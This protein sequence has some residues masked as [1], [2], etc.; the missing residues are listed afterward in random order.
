MTPQG[1]CVIASPTAENI[2]ERPAGRADGARLDL[3][4]ERSVGGLVEAAPAACPAAYCR[5]LIKGEQLKPD[6]GR[7]DDFTWPRSQK[8]TQRDQ[9]AGVARNAWPQPGA[10]STDR[11]GHIRRL[12]PAMDP[13]QKSEEARPSAP[14]TLTVAHANRIRAPRF[15]ESRRLG[16]HRGAGDKPK[17]LPPSGKRRFGSAEPEDNP[18]ALAAPRTWGAHDGRLPVMTCLSNTRLA[19][20]RSIFMRARP[21][22]CST[23]H[24]WG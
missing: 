6:A 23:S 17:G 21:L 8:R 16:S 9:M 18:I 20:L 3:G 7:A 1:R 15:R 10:L 12:P 11:S 13:Q 22:V 14:G 5:V 24:I 19:C 4:G 2:A